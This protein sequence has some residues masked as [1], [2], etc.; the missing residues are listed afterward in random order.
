MNTVL[1]D[2]KD[3]IEDS[4]TWVFGTNLFAGKEPTTPNNTCVVF[5]TPGGSRFLGTDRDEDDPGSNAYEYKNIQIR[6]RN[7]DYNQGILQAQALVDLL[8]G[9]GNLVLNGTL[10]TLIQSI[11]SPALLDWDDNGRARIITNFEIQRTPYN[12]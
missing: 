4:T 11:D 1:F 9:I 5:D 12:P 8:H 7:H 3:L 10:Y 2:L 6:I